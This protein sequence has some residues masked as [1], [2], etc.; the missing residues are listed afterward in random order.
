MN[1]GNA[2]NEMIDEFR[3][4]GGVAQ[5][6]RLGHGPFGRGLFP[7]EPSKP[8][9]IRIPEDLLVPLDDVVIENNV[10]RISP[11]SAVNDR[12]RAF[13][14]AYERDFA[15][16]QGRLE[17]ERSFGAMNELPEQLRIMLTTKF[18]FG[19]FF[20][21]IS[22][23]MVERWFFGT[24]DIKF[25]DR[26][27]IMPIIEMANH[28]GTADY[29]TQSG[30]ALSGLFDGEVLVRYCTPTDPFDMF[31][32]WMFAPKEPMAFSLGV[33]ATNAGRQIEIRR[34]FAGNYPQ[35]PSVTIENN[36]I[37]VDYLLL[38]SQQ[39]PR[40]PKGTFRLAASR[41]FPDPDEAFDFI[42]FANRQGL[43]ELL[44]ALEGVDLPVVPILRTLALNQLEA[45]SW[46]FGARTF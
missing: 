13:V 3:A 16:G 19:R 5:N 23:K 10:F 26:R 45:L 42:Q 12:V 35:L 36:R 44:N 15:W 11:A 37:V 43:L 40:L 6:V 46:Y 17:V 8:I 27:V 1:F 4:L 39:F 2:W 20:D 29:D 18:G 21:S 34:N 41:Y 7:I 31:L 28:G 22:P 32:N 33:V 38:G 14:E 25:G 30:V 9:D 24:R